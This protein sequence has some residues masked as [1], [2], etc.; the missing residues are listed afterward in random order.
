MKVPTTGFKTAL[1]TKANTQS[2][3]VCE[4]MGLDST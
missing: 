3:A 1:G 2:D 4:S